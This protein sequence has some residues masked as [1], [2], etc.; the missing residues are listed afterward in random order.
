MCVSQQGGVDLALEQPPVRQTG[1]RVVHREVLV[2]GD[3][4]PKVV[5]Q[6]TALDRDG[7]VVGHREEGTSIGLAER[8][9]RAAAVSDDERA[10]HLPVEGRAVII[11]WWTSSARELRVRWPA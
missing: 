2:L 11:A 6:A 3:V 8:P 5:D 1:E 10:P 4:T 7:D 9:E